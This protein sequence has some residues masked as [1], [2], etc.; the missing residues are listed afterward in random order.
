[1]LFYNGQFCI[2]VLKHK[3]LGVLSP[4]LDLCILLSSLWL[5]DCVTQGRRLFHT[6]SPLPLLGVERTGLEDCQVSIVTLS[7]LLIVPH[8]GISW[9]WGW[10]VQA[11]QG[12]DWG[13][14]ESLVV[15]PAPEGAACPNHP[16]VR[17]FPRPWGI[18]TLGRT[19]WGFLGRV[20]WQHWI[21]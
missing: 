11:K 21:C 20:S 4:A 15:Y 1:M 7:K 17:A 19:G 2:S 16:S 6:G 8:L 3:L 14:I 10:R 12:G 18:L 9:Q 5:A 13:T